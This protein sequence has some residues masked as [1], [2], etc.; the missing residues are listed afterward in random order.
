MKKRMLLGIVFCLL[1]TPGFT[2][3][4]LLNGGQ[5][6]TISYRMIQTVTP[7]AATRKIMLSYVSPVSYASPTYNQR[8]ENLDINFSPSPSKR[9]SKTDEN[10]N[11]IIE[12]AW[13]KPAG[14]ITASIDMVAKNSV[15]LE[16]LRTDA[17]FPV[18]MMP[19]AVK[20]YLAATSQVPADNPE[21]RRKARELTRPAETQFDAVQLILT[22]VVDH[23]RYVQ[24][25]QSYD[26]MYAFHSGKGNCQNY[27]HLTAALIRAVGIPVRIVNGVT[28]DEPYKINQGGTTLVMKNAQGRHSWIEVYFPD[29]KWVPFDPQCSQLFVSNR[30]IRIEVGLDNNDTE[31]DGLIRWTRL[32]GTTDK[33]A[34]REAI[35]ADFV[36][37][38]ATL[39]GKRMDYGPRNKLLGPPVLADFKKTAVAIKKPEPVA[40]TPQQM[41]ALTYTVPY[42]FGNLE[43]P[44]NLDFQS[45]RGHVAQA[46]DG[47]M[48][49]VKNFLVETAEYVTTQGK[50]YAQSFVLEKPVRLQAIGLALHNFSSAGQLWIEL[51]TSK[52]GIPGAPIATSDLLTVSDLPHQPGYRWVDFDFSGEDIILLP[53]RYWAALGFTGGPIVNWF[54]SYGKPTGPQ[55]GTR[56]RTLFDEAWSHSLA[57]E[58]NYRIKGSIPKKFAN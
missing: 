21:I 10:G 18:A 58:F 34:F 19:G 50:K 12:V 35:T 39:A 11:T 22:W 23:M 3:N 53:G 48:K 14:T 32:K 49:I 20:K 15:K 38:T 25:P 17:P 28:L 29:L 31:N 6:S 9:E 36:S 44:E 2:E 1:A 33:P 54:F 57:F 46:P 24:P 42:I 43:F 47:S 8:I 30:F 16:A 40:L 55:D 56:Y 7:S 45:A 4:Y 41:K 37:D 13:D 26:A 52:N 5:E 27:S 51:S